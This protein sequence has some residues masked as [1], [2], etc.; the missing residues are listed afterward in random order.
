MESVLQL[1]SGQTAI[2]GGLMQD[3]QQYNRSATP[4]A[5]NPAN[6]GFFSELFGA[7]DD[8]VTKSELVIFLRSTIITNPSLDSEELKGFQQFLPRQTEKPTESVPGE[9]TGAAR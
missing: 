7:R 4:G 8:K 5:G 2:L 1:V 9:K 3:N 6:T